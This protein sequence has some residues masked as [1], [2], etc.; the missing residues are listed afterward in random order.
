MKLTRVSLGMAVRTAREAAKLTLNDLAIATGLTQSSLSR[1]EIGQR[2]LA[3]TEVLAIAE[4][5]KIEVSQLRDLA[6]TFE[7][8]G[9]SEK[10]EKR[11]QLAHDLNELQR[12]AIEAAIE[13]RN[14]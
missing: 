9:V 7:R 1:S 2:D 12:T 6:E 10:A 14:M 4:V 5:L 13:A 11:D 3:F 8:D